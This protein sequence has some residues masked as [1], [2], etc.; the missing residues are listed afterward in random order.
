M[1]FSAAF[2]P[3]IRRPFA[4]A[5]S[6]CFLVK[7]AHRSF[8]RGISTPLTGC[9]FLRVHL[10]AYRCRA[11]TLHGREYDRLL[12]TTDSPAS[13]EPVVLSIGESAVLQPSGLRVF[14]E[15]QENFSEI[16]NTL[17]TFAV[18]CDTI[19]STTQILFRPRQMHDE[20]RVSGGRKTLQ[21]LMID[22]KT[23]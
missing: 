10:P 14:C 12:L 8:Q 18:K 2:L 17:S 16:Q 1:A 11:D 5:P 15:W 23:R 6:S 21:K 20:M 7:S 13:F 19:D 9:C 3:R 22:R 4:H